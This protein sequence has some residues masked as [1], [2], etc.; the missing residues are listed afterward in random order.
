MGRFDRFKKLERAR[1]DAPD[2]AQAQSSHRFAKIEAPKPAPAP[3]AHD[4]FAP[5]PEDADVPLEIADS[6]AREI[7]RAKAEKLARA[8]AQLDAEAQRLA[9]M[10]MRQEAEQDGFHAI[11]KAEAV[12]S[13]S[14]RHRAYIMGGLLAGIAL[15]AA[16]VGPFVWGLAPVVILGFIASLFAKQG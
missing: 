13:L 15:V 8:Q 11:E 4:P 1:P 7:E 10:R 16:I 3:A 2:D 9:E 5:P 14:V 12:L 6:D